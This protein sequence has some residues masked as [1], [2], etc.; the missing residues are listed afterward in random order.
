MAIGYIR[1]SDVDT[2]CDSMQRKQ[3]TLGTVAAAQLLTYQKCRL[4]APGG[5][6]EDMSISCTAS[7]CHCVWIDWAS[8]FHLR[9]PSTSEENGN[10]ASSVIT[11]GT[12]DPTTE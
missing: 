1:G 9:S 4:K 5:L 7:Q 6:L 11:R 12:S 10:R 8:V 3:G 2:A